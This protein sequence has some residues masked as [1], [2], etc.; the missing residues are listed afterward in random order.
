[1]GKH[2]LDFLTAVCCVALAGLIMI[3]GEVA[4][5]GQNGHRIVA[6]IAERRLTSD[7]ALEAS[8]ILDGA[9][10]AEV[11]TWADEI[12]SNP[13][14]KCADPF[15]YVTIPQ[16]AQY[17][18]KGIP[19]EGDAGAALVYFAEV[20]SSSTSG[21]EERR[22]A[23]GFLVHLIGDLHQP[24]HVGLGCDR[25]GNQIQLSWFGEESNLHS[26]WDRKIIESRNLSFTEFTEFLERGEAETGRELQL[27]PLV[28]MK[29]AQ[30]LAPQIYQCRLE[31]GC[32]CFC[33][34]CRDGAS[35]FGGC[36]VI[37][38][39]RLQ[40][41]AQVRLSWTYRALH[42]ETV[43]RR[44]LMAGLRLAGVLNEVL[45]ADSRLPRGFTELRRRLE[46]FAPGWR[47]AVASCAAG[48]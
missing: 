5:W 32:P 11:S 8:R 25:G 26:V 14:W 20:L 48:Q 38:G 22:A 33:G 43:D 18:K 9:S 46:T 7:A 4:A 24:L 16:G 31:D 42:S 27:N 36:E 45:S 39:C 34:D 2:R 19:E 30:A 1:M 40:V 10:L 37:D 21:L 28:W 17:G 41:G 13:R 35:A 15:H 29:E 23:L 44:L 3:P 47:N 12:R 6:E